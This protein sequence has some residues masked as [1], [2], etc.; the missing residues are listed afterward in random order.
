[1]KLMW[2]HLTLLLQF[3]NMSKE[4]IQYDTRLFAERVMTHHWWPQPMAPLQRAA[5]PAFAPNLCAAK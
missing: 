3:G 5:V 4:L 1:M 2:L